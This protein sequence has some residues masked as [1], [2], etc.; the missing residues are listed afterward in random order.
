MPLSILSLL[1]LVLVF[2]YLKKLNK[3][4]VKQSRT[5]FLL[6]AAMPSGVINDDDDDD[7]AD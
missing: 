4:L 2:M 5:V 7:D 1:V 6:C 3:F